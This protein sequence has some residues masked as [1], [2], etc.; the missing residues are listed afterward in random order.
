[1]NLSI[2]DSTQQHDNIYVFTYFLSYSREQSSPWEAK[3]FATSQEIPCILLN[4]KVHY[5]F[6]N[7]PPPVSI[8]SQLN[9]VHI[10]QNDNSVIKN[11][12]DIFVVIKE[13]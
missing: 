7:C 13:S 8:L 10:Y 11:G 6:H 9:P 4:P 3:R 1:M 12:T 5:S 2:T